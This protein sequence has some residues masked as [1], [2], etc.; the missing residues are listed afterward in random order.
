MSAQPPGDGL[1]SL[2]TVL[3]SGE[4]QTA[5]NQGGTR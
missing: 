3:A 1:V 5:V 4:N 2:A